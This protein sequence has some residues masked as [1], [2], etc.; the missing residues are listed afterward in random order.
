[1]VLNRHYL[2][3]RLIHC[4]MSTTSPS[5][6]KI[7]HVVNRASDKSVHYFYNTSSLIRVV[8]VY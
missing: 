4:E 6:R 3:S 1:M 2:D 7:N 8:I 5:E